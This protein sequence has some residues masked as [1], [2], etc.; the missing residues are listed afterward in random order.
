MKNIIALELES[1]VNPNDDAFLGKVQEKIKVDLSG[2]V[3]IESKSEDNN[4]SKQERFKLDNESLIKLFLFFKNFDYTP[5]FISNEDEGMW[6]L[7]IYFSDNTIKTFSNSFT[8]SKEAFVFS[9]ALRTLLKRPTILALDKSPKRERISAFTFVLTKDDDVIEKVI[10]NECDKTLKLYKNEGFKEKFIEI[11][12]QAFQI[13]RIERCFFYEF[14]LDSF[15]KEVRNPLYKISFNASTLFHGEYTFNSAFYEYSLNL[16]LHGLLLTLRDITK[17][18][19]SFI[20]FSDIEIKRRKD[21][22]FFARV[23]FDN[24]E[25]K[26]SYVTLNPYI[27]EDD[28]A[29]VETDNSLTKARVKSLMIGTI[30]DSP[31]PFTEIKSIDSLKNIDDPII[32]PIGHVKAIEHFFNTSSNV[33]NVKQTNLFPALLNSLSMLISCDAKVYIPAQLNSDIKEE[34]HYLFINNNGE[35]L[36]PCFFNEDDCISDVVAVMQLVSIQEYVRILFNLPYVG[37]G[38]FIYGNE[39]TKV[40][41]PLIRKAMLN[42]F[43]SSTILVEKD[44]EE[45]NVDIKIISNNSKIYKK[46]KEGDKTLKSK[47]LIKVK[48]VYICDSR[49]LLNIKKLFNI[50]DKLSDYG[51]TSVS[52]ENIKG[53]EIYF[54]L[55][56]N[57]QKLHKDKFLDIY[58]C[59]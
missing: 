16:P 48:G 34:T 44:Q 23:S 3:V 27:K 13:E 43:N 53:S 8:L 58:I 59:N 54:N 45:V 51:Y 37:G 26:Y 28:I 35:N 4:L 6:V 31:Y 49:D 14:F 47:G 20:L 46:L 10:F 25:K 17:E 56:K 22:Y 50:F 19:A 40:A 30:D 32:A 36:L 24:S 5:S 38:V 41:K 7:S 2:D 57:W 33:L 1:I 15:T 55:A 21:E 39:N 9:D 12:L 42:G 29:L 52:I 11:K 18:S